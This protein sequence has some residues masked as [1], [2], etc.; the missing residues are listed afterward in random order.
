MIT[1][2]LHL[3]L[4]DLEQNI[5]QIPGLPSN[6][7]TWTQ[8]DI[9]RLATS[10]RE[11]PELF[12]ARPLVVY[13]YNGKYVIIAGNLRY[14]ACRKNN[15]KDVPVFVLSS[16]LPV[17]KLGEIVLKDNGEFGSWNTG[18]LAQDW[19]NLPLEAWGIETPEMEDFSVKNKEIDVGGFSENITL[20][21]KYQEPD[22][23]KVKASLGENKKDTLLKCLGYED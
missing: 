4:A 9:D 15:A 18:L 1:K 6:P 14:D 17:R 20:K 2:L 11:T 19:A 10:L 22:A 21:L 12:E 3:P 5:G 8:L 7:R 23:S 16:D 13:P